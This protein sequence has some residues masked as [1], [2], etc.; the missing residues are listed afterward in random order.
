M[1]TAINRNDAPNHLFSIAELDL[2]DDLFAERLSGPWFRL[3]AWTIRPSRDERRV[4]NV[5]SRQS[6]LLSLESFAD[7][8][9]HQLNTAF[10]GLAVSLGAAIPDP[11]WRG[12]VDSLAGRGVG[13]CRNG[14]LELISFH[15]AERPPS[16]DNIAP[17]TH[18]ASE[19]VRKST[20]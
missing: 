14:T 15:L 13:S 16:T 18:S 19:E 8:F 2:S 9:S 12:S 4:E 10:A 5:V 6:F 7:I 11:L 17:V 1:A 3:G 20:H